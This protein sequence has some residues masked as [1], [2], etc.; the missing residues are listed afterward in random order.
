MQCI[1]ELENEK[2]RMTSMYIISTNFYFCVIKINALNNISQKLKTKRSRGQ[3]VFMIIQ[4]AYR[5]VRKTFINVKWHVIYPFLIIFPQ[6]LLMDGKKI[7]NE[8]CGREK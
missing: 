2:E 6:I 8:F 4:N 1:V 3:Y 7:L 5:T